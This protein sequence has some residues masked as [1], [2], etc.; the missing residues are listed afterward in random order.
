M[1]GNKCNTEN[2]HKNA[3]MPINNVPCDNIFF[4]DIDSRT[5]TLSFR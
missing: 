5:P 1:H 3:F 4:I 2:L